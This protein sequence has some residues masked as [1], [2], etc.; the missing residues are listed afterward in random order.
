MVPAGRAGPDDAWVPGQG[1]L[2][3]LRSFVEEVVIDADD[4]LFSIGPEAIAGPRP[5]TGLSHQ[6][7]PDRVVVNVV[8]FFCEL[9]RRVDIEVVKARLPEVELVRG[10]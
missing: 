3:S 10:G 9:V 4:A 5:V 6:P 7:A 8:Q 2:C 1:Y